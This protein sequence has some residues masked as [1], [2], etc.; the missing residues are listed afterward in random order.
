MSDR[1]SNG[2]E[3]NVVLHFKNNYSFPVSIH[4]IDELPPQFQERNWY[5]NGRIERNSELQI[6]YSLK[7]LT[8]GEYVYGNINV[9]AKGPLQLVQRRFVFPAAQTVK[10]YPSYLQMRR[11]HLLAVS[12]R[13]QEAGVKR[14]RRLGH[15]M[16]FEQIKE[17]VRGDDYRTDG[18]W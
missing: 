11:Y 5:R 12:N 14:V 1:L 17:Y 16:E 9:F 13:L 10:V 2:D 18:S 3:N 4:I 8:R 15:S 7:P 6:V